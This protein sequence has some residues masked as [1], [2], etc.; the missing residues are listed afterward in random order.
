MVVLTIYW[1]S[2]Q[3]PFIEDDWLILH[4]IVTKGPGAFL[5]DILLPA[6]GSFYRPLGQ[7]FVLLGYLL[8]GLDPTGY[9]VVALIVHVINTLLV[10]SL[11]H[12]ITGDQWMGWVSAFIY[13]T[14]VSV[15]MDSLLMIVGFYDLFG[16]LF[17]LSSFLLHVRGKRTISAL[18]YFLAILTKEATIVLPAILMLYT[19]LTDEP[20]VRK[21]GGR[22][23][24]SLRMVTPH[25]ALLGLFLAVD[26]RNILFLSH[27]PEGNGYASRWMGLHLAENIYTY[28]TWCCQIFYPL[29]RL[30]WNPW[31]V[32]VLTALF[33]LPV[34]LYRKRVDK[35]LIIFF[36]LWFLIGLLPVIPLI[37][38]GYRYYLKHSLPAFCGIIFT[39]LW[40]LKK[41]HRALFIAVV[42]ILLL[43][44]LA[45]GPD[46]L[47]RQ[48][49]SGL[50]RT[51]VEGTA[52]LPLKGDLV[53][54]LADH[55]E[56]RYPHLPSHSIL[57]LDALPSNVFGGNAA[58][59]IWY[60]DTTLKVYDSWDVG[61]D[62]LGVYTFDSLGRHFMDP[63]R[64]ILLSFDG[65]SIR[66]VRLT[67]E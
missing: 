50:D 51:I 43:L 22:L 41:D 13:A 45:V 7:T 55:L 53:K 28:W 23:A 31:L 1:K 59:Q 38:H 24:R 39:S 63:R 14:A 25:L 60:R 6:V 30:E 32:I 29:F 27:L 18:L 8:F 54:M 2:L 34:Y 33:A 10:A 21:L 44:S 5:R 46:F 19:V 56:S 40:T 20:G 16:A 64:V 65:D 26:L 47:R 66:S 11:I 36:T 15:Q 62:S 48:N 17:L 61:I 12:K 58:A 35:R 4:S 57:V 37:H 67:P 42:A 9:H 49:E 3:Y 52:N